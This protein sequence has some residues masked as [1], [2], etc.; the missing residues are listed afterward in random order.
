MVIGDYTYI[1]Y[2]HPGDVPMVAIFAVYQTPH[3]EEKN[4]EQ[5]L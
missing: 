5:D 1:L 2:K 3:L 4:T